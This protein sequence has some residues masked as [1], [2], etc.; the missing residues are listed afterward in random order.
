MKGYLR[1]LAYWLL[2]VEKVFGAMI[3]TIAVVVL[4][5]ASGNGL[6][7]SEMLRLYLP[8]MGGIFCLAIMMS[9]SSYYIPQSMSMGATRKEV[10]FAMAVS[11]H[12]VMVETILTA[13]LVNEFVIKGVFAPEY[14]RISALVYVLALGAGNLMCML[15]MKF[16]NKIAMIVYVVV[17]MMFAVFGGVMG[18]FF[19]DDNGFGLSFTNILEMI[20]KLWFIPVIVDVITLIP[21]WLS[22]RKYEVKV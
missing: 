17:V 21:C 3:A 4:L 7:A 18:A 19:A 22:L 10:F 11:M 1:G 13:I 6:E 14:I 16:G 15:S 12:L 20:Q 5:T 9:A 2:N 8:M